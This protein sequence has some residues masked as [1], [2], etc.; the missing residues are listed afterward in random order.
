MRLKQKLRGLQ[1]SKLLSK[2][3]QLKPKR[4]DSQL[5]RRLKRQLPP[6]L[7]ESD[8]RRRPLQPLRLK[9]LGSRKKKLRG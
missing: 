4:Q 2:R 6:R 1:N 5:R 9:G 7:R 3:R 8:L